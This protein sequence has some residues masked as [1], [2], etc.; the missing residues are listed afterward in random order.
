MALDALRTEAELVSA[1][2]SK[3]IV[4]KIKIQVNGF[5]EEAMV[6]VSSLSE[7]L[8]VPLHNLINASTHHGHAHNKTV[9]PDV[10]DTGHRA[11]LPAQPQRLPLPR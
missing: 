11:L 10:Q 5:W 4:K 8:G 1:T 7:A 6:N 9:G 2:S 3:N